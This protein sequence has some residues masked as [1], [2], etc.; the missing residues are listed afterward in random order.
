MGFVA[1]SMSGCQK[2]DVRSG[3]E[4]GDADRVLN[5][6]SQQHGTPVF[7]QVFSPEKCWCQQTCKIYHDISWYT[8]NVWKYFIYDI[9]RRC[10]NVTIMHCQ[11]FRIWSLMWTP[12]C[13]WEPIRKPRDA[14]ASVS[15]RIS[16]LFTG[17][18]SELLDCHGL[19]SDGLYQILSNFA[20]HKFRPIPLTVFV[21]F[22]ACSCPKLCASKKWLPWCAV[23]VLEWPT[24]CLLC[25]LWIQ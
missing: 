7:H 3:H 14:A 20:C 12:C 15:A 22:P 17:Y 1:Q 21:D 8:V 16:Q 25:L 24:V 4:R 5:G 19:P 11:S 9:R 6:A 10:D 18:E 2:Q 13:G 23:S